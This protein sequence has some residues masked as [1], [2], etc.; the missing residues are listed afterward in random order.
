MFDIISKCNPETIL[1]YSIYVKPKIVEVIG[2]STNYQMMDRARV[3][4]I[5]YRERELA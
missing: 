2:N 3:Y 4:R 5:I 1:R